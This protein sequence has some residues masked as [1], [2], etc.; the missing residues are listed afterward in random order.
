[1][2]FLEKTLDQLQYDVNPNPKESELF[3]RIRIEIIRIRI[4]SLKKLGQGTS[5]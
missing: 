4:L 1:M 5:T 3:S 2:L